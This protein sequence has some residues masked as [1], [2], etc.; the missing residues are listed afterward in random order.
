[1]GIRTGLFGFY[2]A[3]YSYADGTASYSGGGM[4][5][6]AVSFQDDIQ[7]S[8]ANLT[9]GT[10]GMSPDALKFLLGVPVIEKTV[11]GESVSLLAWGGELRAPDIGF[12]LIEV[13]ES[14]GHEV[15]YN[16]KIYVKTNFSPTGKTI[17]TEGESKEFQPESLSGAAVPSDER[18]V[19]DGEPYSPIWVEP[20]EYFSTLSEA[21][22]FIRDYLNIAEG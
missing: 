18:V 5:L 17:N 15:K 13:L 20:E 16:P 4:F 2:A 19:V 21:D 6:D 7:K 22:A 10:D 14:D 11:G 9:V 8:D 12:G 1:M 3:K